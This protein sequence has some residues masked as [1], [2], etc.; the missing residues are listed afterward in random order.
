ML[1]GCAIA[2]LVLLALAAGSDL[3]RRLIPNQLPIAIAACF[4]L[5]TIAEPPASALL[6]AIAAASAVFAAGLGLFAANLLGGGDVKLLAATT[7]WAGWD[8]IALAAGLGKLSLSLRSL[9]VTEAALADGTDDAMADPAQNREP[10]DAPPPRRATW[11]SD[12]SVVVR[13]AAVPPPA[14]A[15]SAPRNVR[16][17]RGKARDDVAN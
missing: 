3:R 5:A 14:T 17:F 15:P 11:A 2:T 12:V 7:L 10:P 9:L 13:N 4:G 16:V 8:Q 6:P 1:V